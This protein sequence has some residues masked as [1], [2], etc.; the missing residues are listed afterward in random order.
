MRPL[1]PSDTACRWE[2]CIAGRVASVNTA[3]AMILQVLQVLQAP[4]VT[5]SAVS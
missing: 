4:S 5:G 3:R 1:L 2:R